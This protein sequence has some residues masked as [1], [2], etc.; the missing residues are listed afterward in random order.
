MTKVSTLFIALLLTGLALLAPVGASRA[1]GAPTS[2]RLTAA[3]AAVYGPY[4]SY[5]SAY[6]VACYLE[7]RGYYTTIYSCEGDYYVHAY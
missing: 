7:D 3:R 1:A 5:L 4:A 6:R 2:G